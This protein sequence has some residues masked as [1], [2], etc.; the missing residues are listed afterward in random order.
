MVKKG[1]FDDLFEDV[2]EK[3]SAKASPAVAPENTVEE[4][5]PESKSARARTLRQK[6]S[7]FEGLFSDEYQPPSKETGINLKLLGAAGAGAL[8][9]ALYGMSKKPVPSEVSLAARL[10]ERY[11]GLPSGALTT[12]EGA[13]P[14]PA[15]EASMVAARTIVPQPQPFAPAP[16]PTSTPSVETPLSAMEK[17]AASQVGKESVLPANVISQATSNYADDPTGAPQIIREQAANTR[18]ARQLAPPSSMQTSAGGIPY[19][20]SPQEQRARIVGEENARRQAAIEAGLNEPIGQRSASVTPTQPQQP[21][22][23]QTAAKIRAASARARNLQ[24]G[25]ATLTGG[26]FGAPLAAQ[27]YTMATQK[28]PIDWTQLL[29]LGGNALGAFGPLTSKV[30][31]VGRVPVAGPLATLAQI[32]YAV[33]NREALFRALEKSDVMPPGIVTG[34]EASEPAFPWADW[35]RR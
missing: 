31:F 17:W 18:L 26:L 21:T 12:F 28:E 9:G 5:S 27:G 8:G 22:V 32:P 20:E 13:L 34:A 19:V 4:E 10:M 2:P 7:E 24:R 35:A 29:S 14:T 11:Y 25:S 6:G 1:E 3:A 15:N 30:P 33:K 23:E 16:A